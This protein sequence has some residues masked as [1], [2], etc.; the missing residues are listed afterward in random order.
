MEKKLNKSLK[1]VQ[2]FKIF[3]K[4]EIDLK[5]DIDYINLNESFTAFC[6]KE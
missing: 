3:G 5:N 6:L 1:F 4:I 2:Q